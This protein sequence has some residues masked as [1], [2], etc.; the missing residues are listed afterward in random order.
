[1]SV[2]ELAALLAQGAWQ[3]A[4][5]HDQ[6]VAWFGLRCGA[7][8]RMVRGKAHNECTAGMAGNAR[9]HTLQMPRT[10]RLSLFRID[11]RFP[12]VMQGTMHGPKQIS[13]AHT[14]KHAPKLPQGMLGSACHTVGGT[15]AEKR[16]HTDVGKNAC[17]RV[18]VS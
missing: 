9:G 14:V 15:G 16:A 3:A 2:L 18:C 8:V 11:V 1:M 12:E 4:A 10:L 13:T 5:V 17:L 6:V 7:A